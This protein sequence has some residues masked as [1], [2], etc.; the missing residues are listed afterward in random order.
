MLKHAILFA[1][2][3]LITA[4]GSGGPSMLSDTDIPTSPPDVSTLA[5]GTPRN[6]S[7]ACFGSTGC[8]VN[9]FGHETWDDAIIYRSTTDNFATA[10]QIGREWAAMFFVDENVEPGVTYYYWV[11]FQDDRGDYSTISRSA[12]GKV[13]QSPFASGS[14]TTVYE[15]EPARTLQ[16][17]PAASQSPVVKDSWNTFVGG[18]GEYE[19]LPNLEFAFD[20]N[21]IHIGQA[22]TRDGI[23]RSTLA[24]FLHDAAQYESSL[25]GTHIVTRLIEPAVVTYG[26]GD[27][28]Q[29]DVDLLT[30]AVQIVNTTLPLDWRLQMSADDPMPESGIHVE[31]WSRRDYQGRADYTPG[32]LGVAETWTWDDGAISHSG[33]TINREYMIDGE[34]AAVEVLIHEL[35][36]A[37]G[38]GHVGDE[39]ASLMRAHGN[40]ND[41]VAP[42]M[43]LHPIDRAALRAIYGR[44]SPGDAYYDFGEWDD[45]WYH[46]VG[47]SEHVEFGVSW[48]NGYGEPWAFGE[49]PPVPLARNSRLRGSA[50]WDGLLTGITPRALVVHGI[51]R[52]GVDLRDL[53]GSADFTRME[54][55]ESREWTMWGDGDLNYSIAVTGNTFMQTGGDEGYL[56]GAFFGPYHEGVGGTLEREDLTAAFGGHR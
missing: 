46:T 3:A 32:E 28:R 6:I 17:L 55:W 49:T 39:W 37:L 4:C 50:S 20:Y 19:L 15:E 1:L 47:H 53:S 7:V 12:S 45:L 30:R 44:M 29:E 54:K 16:V 38:L 23:D 9:W 52:V 5:V 31:F 14:P 25:T 36:H 8:W 43:A 48:G 27:L 33:I 35:V 34:A 24:T 11:V 18:R 2:A 22:T 51:A 10:Q 42:F 26:G 41:V 13:Q 40:W 21:G 56:T